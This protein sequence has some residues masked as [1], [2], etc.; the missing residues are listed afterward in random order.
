VGEHQ[1]PKRKASGIV[2]VLG[3]LN[4]LYGIGTMMLGILPFI[5]AYVSLGHVPYSLSP[6]LLPGIILHFT[7]TALLIVG[8]IG[9]LLL[10]R[11]GRVLSI[12]AAAMFIALA[13]IGFARFVLSVAT[14]NAGGS[15]PWLGVLIGG[16]LQAVVLIYPVALIV[17]L[18]SGSVKARF[19]RQ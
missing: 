3:V 8:G 15:Q 14:G 13:V 16:A 6:S 12:F 1:L 4:I 2:V 7:M 11:W 18:N 17:L 9:L 19:K 5:L 10:T